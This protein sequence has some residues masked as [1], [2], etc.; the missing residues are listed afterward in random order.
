MKI[1]LITSCFLQLLDVMNGFKY[2]YVWESEMFVGMLAFHYQNN[3]YG[4]AINGRSKKR[5]SQR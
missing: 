1:C 3:S 4:I 5:S 2:S